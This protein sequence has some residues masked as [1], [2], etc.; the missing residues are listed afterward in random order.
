LE[1]LGVISY[2]LYLTHQP[3]IAYLKT[4]WEVDNR[5]VRYLLSIPVCV[6]IAGLFFFLIERRFLHGPTTQKRQGTQTPRESGKATSD[7]AA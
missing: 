4:S 1:Q 6:L 2:S 5:F 3:V 7:L